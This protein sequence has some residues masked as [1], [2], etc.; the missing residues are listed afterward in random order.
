MRLFIGP[1]AGPPSKIAPTNAPGSCSKTPRSASVWIR[2]VPQPPSKADLAMSDK[3]PEEPGPWGDFA[4]AKHEHEAAEKK[5]RGKG[6]GLD[7]DNP[8]PTAGSQPSISLDDFYAYMPMHNYIF[9]PARTPWP[10]ASVNSRIAPIKLSDKSG[11]P[12]L[13][14]D[15]KQVI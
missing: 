5:N 10:G 11:T 14:K 9:V 1:H 2:P 15:G 8:M 4:R 6:N 7:R 12:I 3:P 13:D